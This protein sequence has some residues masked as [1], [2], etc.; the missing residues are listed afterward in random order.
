MSKKPKF[1]WF[2]PVFRAELYTSWTLS[3]AN[4]VMQGLQ[5][6]LLMKLS[7]PWQYALTV[8]V[9]GCIAS[10][11]IGYW[12]VERQKLLSRQNTLNNLHNAEIQKL[13]NRSRRRR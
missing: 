5:F 1:S 12:G 11:F 7:M 10:L 3:R 2:D 4:L 6:F 13:L 9:S 8:V